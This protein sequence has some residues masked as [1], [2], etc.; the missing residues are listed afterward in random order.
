MRGLPSRIQVLEL[1]PTAR[2]AALEIHERQDLQRLGIR[3]R[4]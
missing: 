2:F 3:S 4:L 1:R